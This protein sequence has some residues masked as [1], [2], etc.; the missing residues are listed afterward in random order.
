MT[1]KRILI[2][3]FLGCLLSGFILPCVSASEGSAR[4]AIDTA[5]TAI[6]NA[7]DTIAQAEA[8]GANVDSLMTTLNEAANSLSKAELAY[9][10]GNYDTAYTA[11]SQCQ[12]QLGSTESDANRLK[13]DAASEATQ[14]FLFMFVL[15]VASVALV[16]AGIGAWLILNRKERRSNNAPASL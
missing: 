5:K 10:S 2:L 14:N 7:Y 1:V 12:S 9:S 6:K 8:A 11:A 15:L 3:L 16:G 4:A 13:Q